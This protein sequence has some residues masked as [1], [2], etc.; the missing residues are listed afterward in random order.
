[1]SK[2]K[3]LKLVIDTNL[4]ISFLIS[5]KFNL[6]DSI[7][8]SEKAKILFSEELIKELEATITKPKLQKYFSEDAMDEMLQVFDPYI[9]FINVKNKIIVCRDPNDDFLLA[10]AKDGNA[11]FLLTGDN[12]LLD[13]ENFEKTKI[14]KITDFLEQY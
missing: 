7:L 3:Q 2:N 1:M 9:D 12:D 8:L 4:W 5:R 11:D 13:I 6:L 10:L 14:I